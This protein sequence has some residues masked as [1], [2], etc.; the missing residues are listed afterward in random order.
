MADFTPKYLPKNLA[1][2]LEH[3][4][5]PEVSGSEMFSL[6]RIAERVYAEGYDDGHRRGMEEQSAY[7]KR[8]NVNHVNEVREAL[9]AEKEG[10]P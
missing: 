1:D 9:A 7:D 2:A 10:S 4:A 5:P 3:W 8:P 6:Q